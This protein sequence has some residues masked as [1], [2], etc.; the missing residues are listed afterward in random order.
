[1]LKCDYCCVRP[2]SLKISCLKCSSNRSIQI[3]Y[4]C[5]I[6][7][8]QLREHS[9][10]HPLSTYELVDIPL[11]EN[12][13]SEWLCNDEINLIEMIETCGLGNWSDIA[14]KL[15]KNIND[16][17]NHFE[18]IYLSRSTS[19][20]SI[21]FQSFPNSKQLIGENLINEKNF[22]LNSLIYPPMLID[23][24]QQKMLTYMPQRDEYERE[25]LNQAENRLLISNNEELFNDQQEQD[26]SRLLVHK[27]K[28]ALLRSY[29]QILQRRFKLKD[30]IRDYAIGFNYSPDQ[31][32]FDFIFS[33]FYL[34]LFLIEWIFIK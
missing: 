32:Y 12:N 25:Y 21:C 15:S 13:L 34:K 9:R 31:E 5:S 3:C 4:K 11:D 24:E 30:F 20:Y 26:G 14:L 17:Q 1:M 29:K 18:D 6:N 27:A 10:I 23:S 22:Q 19:P 7:V 8:S 2:S 28:L 16:C 33:S